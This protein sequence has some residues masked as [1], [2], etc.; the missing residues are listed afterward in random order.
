MG[1]TGIFVRVKLEAWRDQ[2]R[3]AAMSVSMFRAEHHVPDDC[4]R[5]A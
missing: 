1:L 2:E 3:P 4:I 5:P